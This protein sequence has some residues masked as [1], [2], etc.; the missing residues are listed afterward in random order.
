MR[1][2][3]PSCGAQYEVPEDVI[4][5][6]GRDVQCSNCGDTWYQLSAQALAA[7][8]ALDAFDADQPADLEATADLAAEQPKRAIDPQVSQILREEAEREV[9]L[10]AA[11]EGSLETQTDLGLEETFDT[12]PA[13]QAGDD[14]PADE[15]EAQ[16]EDRSETP[17][18]VAG[19]DSTEDTV[20]P[21]PETSAEADPQGAASTP[22]AT[23]P[24]AVQIAD[25]SEHVAVA[26]AVQ[27]LMRKSV[28]EAAAVEA[29]TVEASVEQAAE[30]T[31]PP[32]PVESDSRARRS[33]SRRDLL[34][35][36]EDV[37]DDLTGG[38]ASASA[39]KAFTDDGEQPRAAKAGS[40]RN[41]FVLM[42]L[43]MAVAIF[44]YAQAPEIADLLP[45]AGDSLNSYVAWVDSLRLWLD[46]LVR[47]ISSEA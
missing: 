38:D 25:A 21:Q 46:G 4:P 31:A 40:F 14:T 19:T 15:E 47:G 12:A 42:L 13:A 36:I 35:D 22:L 10:R 3:C 26:A 33:G 20:P 27:G 32:A 41:G 29:A 24:E 2:T 7:S 1:L 37:S 5:P 6:E 30:E 39:G 45:G 43:L 9:A 34:P 11:P 28:Q 17:K 23:E 16:V 44:V 18:P 8:S